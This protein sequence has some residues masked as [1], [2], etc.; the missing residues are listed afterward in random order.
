[1]PEVVGEE[2]TAVNRSSESSGQ[3]DVRSSLRRRIRRGAVAT[4]IVLILVY[5]YL[6]V[7]A[8]GRSLVETLTELD[9]VLLILPL[10]ATALSYVTMSLSYE[11]IARAAGCRVGQLDM[12]RITFVANTANYVIPTGGL[13]GFALRLVMLNKKGV[14]G[15]RAVLISFT[16]TL[17]TNLMLMVFILY[18]LVHLVFS[19]RLDVVTMGLIAGVIVLLTL[20]L[21]AC[22][23]MV[24]NERIRGRLLLRMNEWSDRVLARFGYTDRFGRR[25]HR[26][27]LHVDEGLTFFAAE[28]RAMAMPLFWIFLDWVFT[29][30]VLYAALYSVGADVSY[31]Q[32]VVAF[33]V[34]IVFA[35][36]SF[37]PAGV[38]VLE[39]ALNGMLA[40]GGV[41][42]EQSVLAIM[43]FRICFYVIPVLL[44]LFV[45]R[46]AFSDMDESQAEELV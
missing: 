42:R 41:P 37:V 29:I 32:V 45:A 23:L 28:P 12:L 13:S 2:R 25:A 22:L 24:Y 9:P 4:G 39:V 38:G 20:F 34:G 35:V 31:G 7:T 46:G 6:V 17:L 5:A 30:A 1:L 18:G 27:L 14:S 15:G 43:I 21:A 26:F 8:G 40:S 44:A 36:V 16:Q 33:S 11:G 10:I 19:R 3:G